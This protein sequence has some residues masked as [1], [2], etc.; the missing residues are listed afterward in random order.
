MVNQTK[1]R[2]ETVQSTMNLKSSIRQRSSFFSLLAV[3]TAVLLLSLQAGCSR[4]ADEPMPLKDS[5]RVGLVAHFPLQLSPKDMTGNNPD[6]DLIE[7]SFKLSARAD[8][9]GEY[10]LHFNGNSSSF[11]R[12]YINNARAVNGALSISF[13]A[14]ELG[15]GSFSPRVFEFWPGN[16]GPGFYWFNWYQGKVKWAGPSFEA[17]SDSTYKRNQWY[18]VMVSHDVN[19]IR[20]FIDGKR[21]YNENLMGSIP[22]AAIQL[23]RYGELGRLA[24]R[25]ADAFHGAVIDFRIYNRVLSQ[26]EVSYLSEQ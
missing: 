7:A 14:K 10:A 23:A 15:P 8:K 12:M 24:Q 4:V 1:P 5:V 25:P 6:L 16:Y 9:A 18:H 2:I 19:A 26:N 11:A 20:I 13:W 22:P 17:P 3:I 21:V